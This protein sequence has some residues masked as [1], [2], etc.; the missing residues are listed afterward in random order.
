M[1]PSSPAVSYTPCSI[2]RIRYSLPSLTCKGCAQPAQRVWETSRTAIDVDLDHPVLLLVTVSVHRCLACSRYFRL[3]PPFL[4][5]NAI[6]TDRVVSKAVYSVYQD[7]MAIRRVARRL[8]RDFWVKP[9]EAMIRRWCSAYAQGLDFEGDYQKWVVEEFSGVLCVDEVYQD[10]LALLLAV[11]P[12]APGSDRLVGYELIH[13]QVERKD[14]EGFLSRLKQ[15]G[16]EPEEVV[17]DGSPLYPGTLKEVW[18]SAAHQLC[19]F[20][21]SKLV[22]AEIYKAMAALRKKST[23]KPPPVTQARSL[24][25]V[26]PKYPLPEKLAAHRAAIARVLALHNQGVS[27]R[28]IRRQTG[29]SRNTIKRWLCGQIPKNVAKGQLPTEWLLSAE[30]K[31]TLSEDAPQEQDSTSKLPTMSPEVP[32]PWS[33]WEKVR[34]VRNLLWKCRYLMLRRP[35]HLTHEDRQELELLFESP[36]VGESVRLVRSFLEEWYSLFYD[37]RRTRRTL[38]EARERYDL[39]MSDPRY[40]TLEPLARLQARFGEAQFLKISEF[41]RRPEW[42]STNNAAERSARAFRHLQAPHYNFRKPPSIENAIRAR[43]WLSKEE[44]SNWT[45]GVPPGRCAR[46]RKARRISEMPAAA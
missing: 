32:A 6:Y 31:K 10:K 18:P 37:E 30:K 40:Q 4:R 15:A 42:E 25:G 17:T 27:I 41:L 44:E 36:V 5:R 1:S 26:P 24:K 9:S 46:G 20:H 23:P 39:L 13:G 11:D 43:A 38:E 3:Q 21:E 7:G 12:A 35:D 19:L 28:G 14:V 2:R 22:I 45:D 8:A 29:H 16:I 33:S 34:E